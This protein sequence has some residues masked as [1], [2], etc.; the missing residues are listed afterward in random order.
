MDACCCLLFKLDFPL[1]GR[2]LVH[3]GRMSRCLFEQGR[4]RP[5]HDE[6]R[7]TQSFH[8][9]Q[10]V[11][12]IDALAVLQLGQHADGHPAMI[13]SLVNGHPFPCPRCP[14]SVAKLVNA[15]DCRA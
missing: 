15:T 14:Y 11:L 7:Q 4:M 1:P 10:R 2:I 12:Q 13:G 5:R 6:H 8:H 9:A 3:L